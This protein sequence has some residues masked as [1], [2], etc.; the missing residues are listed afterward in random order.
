M[1]L[2][3]TSAKAGYSLMEVLIAFA[4]LSMVLMAIIPRQATLWRNAAAAE[5]TT[6]ALDYV[7]SH[8]ANISVFG[9]LKPGTTQTTY[10]GWKILTAVSNEPL[11]KGKLAALRVSV[12]VFSA[13]GGTE[14]TR[15]ALVV[16]KQ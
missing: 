8:L 7:L 5:E 15:I 4:I 2:K 9:P 3:R 1:K 12:T 11:P 10:R 13:A 16:A 6:L 14:L